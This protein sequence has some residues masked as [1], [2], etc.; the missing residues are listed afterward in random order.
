MF[1]EHCSIIH[2][3]NACAENDF[4]LFYFFFLAYRYSTSLLSQLSRDKEIL[5]VEYKKLFLLT[6]FTC[7]ELVMYLSTT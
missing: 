6:Q 7:G 3:Q 2:Q 4:H 1:F 5:I